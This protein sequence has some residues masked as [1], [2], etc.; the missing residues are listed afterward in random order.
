MERISKMWRSG[1]A[2]LL[3]LC[4][5]VSACP[6]T[7]FAAGNTSA[8]KY[9]S[10]GDSMTN[11]YGL[12][13][14]DSPYKV[15]G[16]LD[17]VQV[18]YPYK[19]QAELGFELTAQLATAA[20]RAEDLNYILRYPNVGDPDPYTQKEFLNY[21]WNDYWNIDRQKS[22]VANVAKIFQNSVKEADVISFCV[23][24]ANFGVFLL[25]R[26]TSFLG[27]MGGTSESEDWVDFEKALAPL[28]ASQKELVLGAY[29]QVVAMLKAQVP[30]GASDL[31]DGIA[32]IIGYGMASYM[33]AA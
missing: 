14:Y 27:V 6:V 33:F 1:L 22:G 30:A 25:T 13:G 23:G 5:L 21:R 18:S 20:M 3:A 17:E 19:L 28:D 12:P 29:E 9:I 7:A 8:K 32:N 4:L 15:N 31:V 26:L 11:G 10:F 16:F 24:N 2:M